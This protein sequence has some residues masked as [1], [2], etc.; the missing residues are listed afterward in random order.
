MVSTNPTK[1]DNEA[2]G[3]LGLSFCL[4]FFL[5]LAYL[6]SQVNC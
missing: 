5:L 6:R 1:I 2:Y 4:V 3:V